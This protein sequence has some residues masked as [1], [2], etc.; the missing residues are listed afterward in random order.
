[1]NYDSPGYHVPE[2]DRNNRIVNEKYRAQYHR[3]PF[4]NIP[5]YMIRYLDFEVVRKLN[6]F[7]FK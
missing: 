4:Q 1:M 6:Y 2:I 5:K 3:L 7:P